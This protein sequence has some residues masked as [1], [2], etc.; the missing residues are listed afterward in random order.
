MTRLRRAF[1]IFWRLMPF[2]LAFVRD[3][4]RWFVLGR[5]ADRYLEDHERRAQRLMR[6]IAALGPTF[7]KLAQVFSPISSSRSSN[8]SPSPRRASDRSTVRCWT[9]NPWP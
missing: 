5:P 9:A 7:I 3:R 1:I 2:V 8:A 6:T 4:R